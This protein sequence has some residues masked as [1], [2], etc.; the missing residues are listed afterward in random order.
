MSFGQQ[1][2]QFQRKVEQRAEAVRQATVAEVKRS[3]NEGSELTGAPGQPVAPDAPAGGRKLRGSYTEKFHSPASAEVS[4]SI[5]WAPDV[6]D[7]MKDGDPM[8][9][10]S[11]VGGFHSVALTRAGFPRIVRHAMEEAKRGG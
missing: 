1:L 4:T 3:L 9:L 10:R 11:D 2:R 7:G 6:E 5:P 8:Q